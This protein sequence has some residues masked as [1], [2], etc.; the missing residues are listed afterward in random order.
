MTEITLRLARPND[1]P[2]L[3][4]ALRGLSADLGDT[5]RATPAALASAG[6]GASPAFRAMLALDGAAALGVALFSPIY[7]TTRGFPGVYVS[8]LWVSVAARGLGLGPKLLGA[9]RDAART[10]WGAG[11]IRL[12]VYADNPRAIAFYDRLGFAVPKGEQSMILEG[13]ALD[14]VG[15]TE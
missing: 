7:S 1:V 2:L 10:E 3:D 8:D 11:F 6:F 14:R 15:D 5:H 12:A 4:T 9:V 13:A